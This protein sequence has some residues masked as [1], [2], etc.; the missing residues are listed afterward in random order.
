MEDTANDGFYLYRNIRTFG[1]RALHAERQLELL[2]ASARE[3]AGSEPQVTAEET[4]RAIVALLTDKGYPDSMPAWVTLR[5]YLSGRMEIVGREVLPCRQRGLRLVYPRAA[6]VMWDV[7]FGCEW[8]SLSLSAAAAAQVQAAHAERG[9]RAVIRCGTDGMIAS[10]GDAP[11]FVVTDYTV[12][13]PLAQPLSDEFETAAAAIADAGLPL[14][15]RDITVD[16]LDTADEV[17]CCDA[18]G[19]T[20]FSG[21]GGRAYMHVLAERVGNRLSAYL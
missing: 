5:Y 10:A 7:P 19:L 6:V 3:F 8:S 11:L 9:V 14:E 4:E 16:M 13:T 12:V 15:R 21:C 1:R 20:A 2:K 18:R 17:F